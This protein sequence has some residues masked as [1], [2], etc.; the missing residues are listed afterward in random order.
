MNMMKKAKILDTD[1]LSIIELIEVV[2]KY[3]E[4][5][6]KLHEKLSETNFKAY[7]KANPKA[8]KINVDL[9]ARKEYISRVEDA[10]K[11]NENPADV[12][13]VVEE[14]EE[15]VRRHREETETADLHK[16]WT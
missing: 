13:P 6:N 14:I 5:G 10:K 7:V 2:E 8:L 4:N 15:D 16:K 3:Y 9:Q 12:K 11:A 1:K